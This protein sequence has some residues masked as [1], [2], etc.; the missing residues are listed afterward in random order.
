MSGNR[1]EWNA[2]SGTYSLPQ[3]EVHVWRTSVDWPAE[4][5]DGLRRILSPEERERSE[6]YHFDI[7]RRRCVIARGL[8]RTLLGRYFGMAPEGFCFEYSAYGKP[9]L[10]AS[11]AGNQ[12][13]F[14]V[15]HSGDFILIALALG[16][17]VGVDVER[18]RTDIEAEGI[19]TRFF[20][21]NERRALATVTGEAQCEAFFAC[22]TRKEAYIK[23]RGDGL[24]LPLDGFDVSLLP[25][26]AARLLATR[27]DPA[28]AR[29]WSLQNLDMGLGYKAA[30]AVEGSPWQLK[31]WDWLD[32]RDGAQDRAGQSLPT[33]PPLEA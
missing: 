20:S 23:A 29:R 7:D 30:V 22:W 12:P 19:A 11:A 27:H 4:R 8:L 13:Q 1:T 33:S 10:P 14:N 28:A 18:M 15:S 9:A 16:R 26:E 21:A 5:L 25:G 6:R 2:P 17:A 31:C 32:G 24:S 3:D